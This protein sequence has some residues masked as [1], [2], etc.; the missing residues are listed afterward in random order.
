[1]PD[2]NYI[3][4]DLT[5]YSDEQ[6]KGKVQARVALLLLKYIFDPALFEK[7]PNILSLFAEIIQQET[8]LQTIEALLRYLYSTIEEKNVNRVKDIVQQAL[9]DEKG[10]SIMGTIAEKFIN[11]GIQKGMLQGM[12]QGMEQ[13]RQQGLIEGI[14]LAV[15][16]RFANDA[17]KIIPLIY[18]I[19]DTALLNKLVPYV[20]SAKSA[21][22]LIDIIKNLQ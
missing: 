13:G 14:A 3:L 8:G 16:S 6:I 7:L 2:F 1:M 22:D 10:A 18:Q 15:S 17:H 5:Q 11:E 4:F 9:S 19:K 20:I 21:D 12:E